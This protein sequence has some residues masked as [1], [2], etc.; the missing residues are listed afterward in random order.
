M[1]FVDL[2]TT[3]LDLPKWT[4]TLIEWFV[5]IKDDVVKLSCNETCLEVNFVLNSGNNLWFSSCL[6]LWE[7]SRCI[8]MMNKWKICEL[9]YF[10]SSEIKKLVFFKY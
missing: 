8:H 2:K 10:K 3:W 9:S 4:S 1:W 6:S 5:F 7:N